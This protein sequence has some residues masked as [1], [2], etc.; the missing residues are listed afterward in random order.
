MITV[1]SKK[2][3]FLSIIYFVV[4]LFSCKQIRNQVE[5]YEVND[6]ERKSIKA[7]PGFTFLKME[8]FS[9]GGQVN[10]VGICLHKETGL[11]FVLIP[12][13]SFQM[14]SDDKNPTRTVNI[15][16]FLICR[17]EVTQGV[18]KK[19]MGTTPW[20]GKEYVMEGLDHPATF[21]SWFDCV[22]F[23]EKTGLRLPTETEWEYA[24]R[25]GS[26]TD[27]CYGNSSADLFKYCNYST[28]AEMD[29]RKFSW[30]NKKSHRDGHDL[31]APVMS[32]L[33]NAFGIFDMHGNVFEWCQDKWHENCSGA[34]TDGSSWESGKSSGRVSRGGSWADYDMTCRSGERFYLNHDPDRCGHDLGFRP[35]FSFP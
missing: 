13:G 8:T 10:T 26:I 35:A 32:Y 1:F 27:Y 30:G 12:D 18:W 23:C 4:V 16:S 25:S 31:T 19:I 21:V 28:V 2:L 5:E 29:N 3:F 9:C 22:S 15:N 11:E 20:V 14:G 6:R 17:T 34:A 7:I 33:P 24:C